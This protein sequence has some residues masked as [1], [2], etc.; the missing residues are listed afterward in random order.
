MSKPFPQGLE[1]YL[2]DAAIPILQE[3][4]FPVAFQLR[5]TKGRNSKLGDHRPPWK[6]SK[7]RIT[8]NRDLAPY[9]F[10]ITLIHELAHLQTHEETRGRIA[11][12]GPEWKDC[13]KRMMTPFLNG[14]VFPEPILKTLKKHMEDPSASMHADPELLKALRE[15]EDP[16]GTSLSE[17]P[18]GSRFLLDKGW[19]MEK[20][21]KLRTRYRCKRIGTERVYL[22]NGSARVK[23]LNEK[24][25]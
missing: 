14:A 4:G 18:E 20:G 12:H 24:E 7:H 19:K 17:L 11:P 23:P 3:W 15:I 13:F 6:G 1:R 8:V 16:E 9:S 2:P 25:A 21:K 5:I 10:L 22:V